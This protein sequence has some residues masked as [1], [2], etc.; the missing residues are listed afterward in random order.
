MAEG[1]AEEHNDKQHERADNLPPAESQIH[2]PG[3]CRFIIPD[4][5]PLNA[6]MPH[7]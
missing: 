4:A 2:A 6:R 5:A 1:Q 3:T 7:Q